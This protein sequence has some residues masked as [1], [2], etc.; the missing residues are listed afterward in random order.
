MIATHQSRNFYTLASHIACTCC[1]RPLRIASVI[2]PEICSSVRPSIRRWRTCCLGVPA[3]VR[4]LVYGLPL[5]RTHSPECQPQR[6]ALLQTQLLR[7]RCGTWLRRNLSPG[8]MCCMSS[9][10]RIKTRH[11]PV[12]LMPLAIP[13]L[14]T[15]RCEPDITEPRQRSIVI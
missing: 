2:K 12:H 9:T 8:I 11:R 13:M 14:P 1:S 15:Q 5:F 7:P 10:R 3:R 4:P 6:A